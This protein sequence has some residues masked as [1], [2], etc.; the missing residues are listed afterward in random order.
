MGRPIQ[1]KWFGLAT[2]AGNQIVVNGVKFADGTTATSAYIVK[3]VG[4][5]SYIV[6]DSSLS[7]AAEIVFMVN[8]TS[9]G[10]LLPSQCFILATPFGGSPVPCAKINQF[11]V[12]LYEGTTINSYSW[13]DIPAFAVGQAD[14]ISGSGAVGAILSVVVDIAGFGYS[15]APSVTFTGGGVGATATASITNGA[16]TG[17][18]VNT[19]GSG[20]TTGGVTIGTV[21]VAVT[22][23]ATA[24]Q[25]GGIIQN[26][27]VVTN[28]GHYYTVAP[29][30][31]ITGAAGSGSVAT[32]TLTNGAV[33]SINVSNGGTGYTNP[34]VVS[35][36]APSA[37][38]QSTAHATI[39][40]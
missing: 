28:G 8:A 36:A 4:S 9:T 19:A 29:T 31:T 30:V 20:Y 5:D 34:I 26:S 25:S 10:A 3:Q 22:A 35:I 6:Q 23:T 21:P 13:S 38:V 17:V 27:V 14:L 18:V 2:L 37:S 12:D 39:S 40:V 15:V 11:R 7:H 32:A 16:V 33:T 1:K 24:T